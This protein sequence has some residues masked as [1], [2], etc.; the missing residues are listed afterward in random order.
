MF[1]VP[2]AGGTPQPVLKL[3]P[4]KLERY[5]TPW[6]L[7]DNKTLLF[8][9]RDSDNW[10]DARI[11]ARRLDTGEQHDVIKGGGDARYVNTGHLLYVK[12]AVLMAVP[13]DAG[14][15]Q[16]TGQPVAMLDGV[17]Q[18][19]NMS[20]GDWETGMAQFAI[21]AA[22]HLVYASGG[23]TP[24]TVTTLVRGDRKGVESPL[25]T[26]KGFSRS[27]RFSPDGQKIAVV[28]R[29]DT[30]RSSDIYVIDVNTGNATRLTSQ[31]SNS[32]PIW[33]P[34]GKRVLFRGGTG[35]SQMLSVAADGSGSVETVFTGKGS[36]IP[37]SATEK[38]LVYL[39][40]NEGKFEIWT[41]PLSGPGEPQ[42]FTESKS[43]QLWAELSPDGRWMAYSSDESGEDELHVQAFPAGEKHIISRD[44]GVMAAWARNGRELF[45]VRGAREAPT[46]QSLMAVDFTPGPVFKAGTPHELFEFTWSNTTPLRSYDVTPDGRSFIGWRPGEQP[47]QRVTKLDIVLNWTDE[48]KKR[49]PRTK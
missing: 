13:F 9:A 47:D 10:D 32:W 12:N 42:R 34:D 48:L 25:N 4:A 22:G 18:S 24:G 35:G 7:P 19:V 2:E 33:S 1:Q 26:A 39:E 38:L 17:M 15:A 20:N 37:A 8:T 31:G 5:S 11:V 43:N 16:L 28:R 40:S 41:R 30:S 27:P 21:S 6:F 23:I 46:K 36:V 14:K 29:S 44:G 49:A 45:Y 3:D